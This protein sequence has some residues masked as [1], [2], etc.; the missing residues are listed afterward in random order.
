MA[1]LKT[2]VSATADYLFVLRGIVKAYPE[3]YKFPPFKFI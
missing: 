3:V 2:V 1:V